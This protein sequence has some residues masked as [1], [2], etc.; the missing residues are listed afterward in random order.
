MLTICTTR[1]S[2]SS[3]SELRVV[4]VD[5][6]S[7]ISRRILRANSTRTFQPIAHCQYTTSWDTGLLNGRSDGH[8]RPE[9]TDSGT[10]AINPVEHRIVQSSNHL[11]WLRSSTKKNQAL[12]QARSFQNK[13]ENSKSLRGKPQYC[14]HLDDMHSS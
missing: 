9:G 10:P 6:G 1:A 8:R 7:G 3:T 4:A 5:R 14:F 11:K 2:R 12:A 13:Q